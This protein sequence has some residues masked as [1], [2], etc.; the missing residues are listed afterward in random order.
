[1]SD[2]LPLLAK[3]LRHAKCLFYIPDTS[4]GHCLLEVIVFRHYGSSRVICPSRQICKRRPPGARPKP[5]K[6]HCA[7]KRISRA[8]STRFGPSRLRIENIPLLISPKSAPSSRHP[9]SSK[10][11]VASSRYVECGLRWTRWRCAREALQGGLKLCLGA[12]S[13]RSAQGERR[14]CVRQKRVVLAPVAGVKLAEADR[15]RP[16]SLGRQS[17]ATE[18]RGIRLREERA[19]S[20]QTIAQGRP[21]ALRWTCMLVCALPCAHCTRDRG[22]SAHPVFPAPSRYGGGK[23]PGTTRARRAAGTRRHIPISDLIRFPLII[24]PS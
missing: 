19:I 1:M 24:I 14:C 3:A 17:A 8:D 11:G 7:Q 18:A 22:C 12:V 5:R 20:R 4:R 23:Q 15:I 21:D 13:D 10:R 16:G 9:A 2:P 6:T